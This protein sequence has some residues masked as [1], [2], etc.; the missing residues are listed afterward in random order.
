MFRAILADIPVAAIRKAF[1]SVWLRRI[2]IVLGVL[3]IFA[4]IWFGFLMTGWE[5]LVSPWEIGRAHV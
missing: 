1:R 4:A 3:G 2:A 5:P